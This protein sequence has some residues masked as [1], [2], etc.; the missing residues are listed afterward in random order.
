[1][2]YGGLLAEIRDED[3]MNML[4][5]RILR[6]YVSLSYVSPPSFSAAR[7]TNSLIHVCAL[8]FPLIHKVGNVDIL[9][10]LQMEINW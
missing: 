5:T 1:M 7:C 3:E 9:V 4:R 6:K 10:Q 2:D 8:S